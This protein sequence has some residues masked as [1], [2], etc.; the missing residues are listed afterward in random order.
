MLLYKSVN[1]IIEINL[2]SLVLYVVIRI[3]INFL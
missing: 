3:S 1:I 2:S